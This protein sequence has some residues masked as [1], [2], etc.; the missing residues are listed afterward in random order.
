[1]PLPALEPGCADII[2]TKN[3]ETPVPYDPATKLGDIFNLTQLTSGI[4]SYQPYMPDK[5]VYYKETA[6]SLVRQYNAY[7]FLSTAKSKIKFELTLCTKPIADIMYT[8]FIYEGTLLFTGIYGETDLPVD[9]VKLEVEMVHGYPKLTGE[10]QILCETTT[11]T[12]KFPCDD[13]VP[14]P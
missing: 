12:T 9:M 8:L 7:D 14:S 11:P 3:V 4:F 5:E 2:L 13:S 10:L 1:M 6:T